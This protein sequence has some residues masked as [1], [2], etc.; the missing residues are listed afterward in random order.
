MLWPIVVNWEANVAGIRH[1]AEIKA[2]LKTL[3]W[4]RDG[5]PAPET[6]PPPPPAAP[7]VDWD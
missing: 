7:W 5:K 1:K 2:V 3:V 4:E 6:L